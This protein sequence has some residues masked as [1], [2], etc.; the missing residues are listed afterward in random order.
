VMSKSFGLPGLRVGWIA[1]QDKELLSKM[2]RMKHYLSI[3]NSGPSERLTLIAL[4]NRDKLLARNC[5]IVDENL[6]KWDAFFAQHEELFDWQRPDGSCMGFPR[7]KGAEGVETFARDLVE[8]SGVLFLP[9]SIYH[10]DL[11]PTPQDRF[12]LGYGRKGLDNGIAALEA[13]LDKS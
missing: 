13:H 7:Y 3:C 8:Q 10:S 9:S 11:S 4:K 5:A 6:P 2:E 1:C 12:R